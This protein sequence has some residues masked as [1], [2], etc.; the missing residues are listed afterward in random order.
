MARKD[1]G[2]GGAH[3]LDWD[4]KELTLVHQQTGDI[5]DCTVSVEETS[6]NNGNVV[7]VDMR[8]VLPRFAQ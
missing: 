5:Y 2:A 7:C 4:A 6:F 8:K 1:K 3:P